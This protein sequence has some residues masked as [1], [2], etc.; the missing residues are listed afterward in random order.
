MRLGCMVFKL[1]P[2]IVAGAGDVNMHS[3]SGPPPNAVPFSR[4]SQ[5]RLSQIV[6]LGV[7]CH[8]LR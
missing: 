4:H 6:L 7:F 8:G 1:L 3:L 2:V 5:C